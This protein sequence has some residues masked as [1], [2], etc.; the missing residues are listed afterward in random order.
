M[1][2]ISEDLSND[3]VFCLD[4]SWTHVVARVNT[5]HKASLNVGFIRVSRTLNIVI[6][7]ILI[8]RDD[9]SFM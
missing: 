2:Y 5:Y 8:K 1:I 4:M 6:C 3:R 7:T 9:K